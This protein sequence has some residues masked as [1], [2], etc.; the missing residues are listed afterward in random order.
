MQRHSC[1]RHLQSIVSKL[2]SLLVVSPNLRINHLL[3]SSLLR[4]VPCRGRLTH[5]LK[6]IMENKLPLNIQNALSYAI[7]ELEA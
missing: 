7:A 3:V 5:R 4:L 6:R 1:Y 2:V